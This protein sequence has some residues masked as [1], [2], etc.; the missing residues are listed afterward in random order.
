MYSIPTAR[1]PKKRPT[2]KVATDPAAKIWGK[3]EPMK[4]M[5]ARRIDIFRPYFSVKGSCSAVPTKLPSLNIE[6]IVALDAVVSPK[7]RWKEGRARVP[8]GQAKAA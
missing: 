7:S 6:T 3:A 4:I 1:P 5:M 2:V 8:P